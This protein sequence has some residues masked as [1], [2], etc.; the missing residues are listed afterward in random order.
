[1]CALRQKEPVDTMNNAVKGLEAYRRAFNRIDDL[2]EYR[3]MTKQ[4]FAQIAQDLCK[5]LK[6]ISDAQK[7]FEDRLERPP[8]Y[9]KGLSLL[10]NTPSI[11]KQPSKG[12]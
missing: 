10:M 5:E 6:K 7:E 2:M 3:G 9:K 1:M 4:Q 8:M 11:F 12:D